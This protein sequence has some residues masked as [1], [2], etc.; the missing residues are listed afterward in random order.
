[1][2]TQLTPRKNQISRVRGNTTDRKYTNSRH[3]SGDEIAE[4]QGARLR[5]EMKNDRKSRKFEET[6]PKNKKSGE[7]NCVRNHQIS[8]NIY[9]KRIS[10]QAPRKFELAREPI[11][12][13][14]LRSLWRESKKSYPQ[15]HRGFWKKMVEK[16][17]LYAR[18]R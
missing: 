7:T 3:K 13:D 1:V 9:Q 5:S 10:G 8:V 17:L 12:R 11:S 6:T 16:M 4:S 15:Q 2:E 18:S 14:R